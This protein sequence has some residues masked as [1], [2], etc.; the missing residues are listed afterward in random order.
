MHY[1]SLSVPA[2]AR[3]TIPRVNGGVT[4]VQAYVKRYGFWWKVAEQS[5]TNATVL[6][7]SEGG[8]GLR[9]CAEII[10][11]ESAQP[12]VDLTRLV[13]WV[14]FNLYVGNNDSHAKNLSIYHLPDKGAVLT[15][16]YDLVCTRVYKNLSASFA[17]AVGGQRNPGNIEY[18]HIVAMAKDI[19]IR[20][21]FAFER[22][23]AL[24]AFIPEAI[25]A[26]IEEVTPHLDN[27]GREMA[28]NLRKLVLVTTR[29][30]TTRISRKPAHI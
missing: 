16:F 24:A 15:P 7:E 4:R 25:E 27:S 22:A 19:G 23:E 20:P 29:K 13:D 8:P 21:D 14:F 5:D 30:S 1:I 28:A 10:R 2:A 26:S 3:V 6:D 9:R 12:A 18:P 17:F 11:A